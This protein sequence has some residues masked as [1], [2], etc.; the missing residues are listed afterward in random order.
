MAQKIM[1]GRIR[2][3]R[4]ERKKERRKQEKRNPYQSDIT[5]FMLSSWRAECR[6]ER[7]WGVGEDGEVAEGCFAVSMV[8]TSS[9]RLSMNSR[10][11]SLDVLCGF[12]SAAVAM[13]TVLCSFSS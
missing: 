6:T 12:G 7:S 8:M 9:Q 4:T 10:R 5:N 3:E 1:T 13:V 2:A 11:I